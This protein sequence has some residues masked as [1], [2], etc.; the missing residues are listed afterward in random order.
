MNIQTFLTLYLI[1]VP[2]FFL[3]DLLWLGVI[4]KNIYQDRLGHLLGEVNWVAALIFYFIFLA[5]LTFFATY[6][7]VLVDKLSVAI[8]YGAFFGF[9]TY[10]TYELTNLALL[11]D[12][13]LSIVYIDIAWGT[14]L[15][16]FV[17]GAA[18]YIWK[19]IS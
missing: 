19:L 2:L 11:K 6:P 7:A 18:F 8:L 14:F 15:G 13:P 17:T 10:V 16:A 9:V 4:A 12:W 3:I 5:G 1:S